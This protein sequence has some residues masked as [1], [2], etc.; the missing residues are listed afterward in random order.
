MHERGFDVALPHLA[1]DLEEVQSVRVDGQHAE[2][3][4]GKRGQ[5]RREVGRRPPGAFVEAA[6]G[7]MGQDP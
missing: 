1:V 5:R 4:P 7:V 6:G 3:V 2:Q